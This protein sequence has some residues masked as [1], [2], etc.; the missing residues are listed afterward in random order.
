MDTNISL[1]QGKKFKK[2]QKKNVKNI[3]RS[4]NFY[5]IK[6]DYKKE[7]F[8][9]IFE[10]NNM[11]V[12]N[13]NRQ[14]TS[15]KMELDRLTGEFEKL[16]QQ[17]TDLEKTTNADMYNLLERY[18]EKNP[19]NGK[20]LQINN[21][22]VG[23]VTKRGDF[24]LFTSSDTIINTRGKNGCPSNL[25]TVDISN[26]QDSRTPGKVLNTTPSLLVGSYMISGQSCGNEGNNIYVDSLV[27]KNVKTTYKGCYADKGDSHTMTFLGTSPPLSTGALQNGNFNQPQIANNSYQYISSND[28]VSGWNFYAVLINNSS[29][30]GFPVPYPFGSQAA[31]IQ[32]S[33]DFGQW[34]QLTQGTYNVSFSACGRP[35][36]VVNRVTEYGAL[37]NKLNEEHIAK[38]FA[39]LKKAMEVLIEAMQSDE[40]D[41]KDKAR[42]ADKLAPFESSRAPIISIEHVQNI[43]KDQE[44]D[45]DES[46]AAFVAT[47]RKV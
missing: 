45:A 32:F 38:G 7:G 35:K 24:K 47:L 3:E 30:W 19:Y 1:I 37:F 2:Y 25:D 46:L 9:N 6:N 12:N 28:K 18:S 36:S 34:I 23:Y 20:L 39:P 10:Q 42:I 21:G 8:T 4:D 33:Q 44:E 14:N 16:S 43:Q 22:D 17:Y 26:Y 5:E 13:N 31:C 11:N 40:L 29:A 27:P 15:D 41:I